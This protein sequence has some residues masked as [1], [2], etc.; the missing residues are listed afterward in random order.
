MPHKHKAASLFRQTTAKPV[1]P[2]DRTA[3]AAREIIET[4][5]AR[6]ADLTASL[7]AARLARDAGKAAPPDAPPA[8]DKKNT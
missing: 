4:E 2:H 7:K 3:A 5:A 8:F 1:T 6:R